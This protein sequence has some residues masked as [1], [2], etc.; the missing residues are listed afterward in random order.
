MPTASETA[1]AEAEVWSGIADRTWELADTPPTERAVVGHFDPAPDLDERGDRW[2]YSFESYDLSDVARFGAG[3]AAAEAA[4]WEGGAPDVATRAYA[5][6]RFLLS[7]R[8]L[9]WA[10]P[11]LDAVGRCYPDLRAVAHSD[12]DALLVLGDH[13]R[14]APGLAEGE[15]VYPAGEDALGPVAEL[16]LNDAVASLWGGA[17]VLRATL[18]SITGRDLGPSAPTLSEVE[19]A[20]EP[21]GI[22]YGVVAARWRR[23]A[24]EHPG[25]AALWSALARRAEHTASR[26]GG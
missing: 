21:L 15:G 2:G 4:A 26:F 13:H 11:W 9:H 17:V 5:E 6:R 16:E 24:G 23:L 1:A 18:R 7:D 22:Y 19:E 8:V 3:L 20:R 25:S 14:P 12:R 10:V